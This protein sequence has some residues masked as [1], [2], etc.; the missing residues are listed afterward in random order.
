MIFHPF[1]FDLVLNGLRDQGQNAPADLS[2][3]CAGLIQRRFCIEVAQELK[4]QLIV[5]VES[6]RQSQ[7][8]AHEIAHAVHDGICEPFAK[9]VVVQFF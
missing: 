5:V 1:D 7:P 9:A 4:R 2:R 8:R 3:R 6:L